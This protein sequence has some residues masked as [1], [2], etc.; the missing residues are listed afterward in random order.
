M[1][2]KHGCPSKKG[3]LEIEESLTCGPAGMSMAN[4]QAAHIEDSFSRR[5]RNSISGKKRKPERDIKHPKLYPVCRKKI[6]YVANEDCEN[7]GF[8]IRRK[9]SI[10]SGFKKRIM[11][12]TIFSWLIDAGMVQENVEIFS[13]DETSKQMK[14]KGRIKREGILCLCCNKVFTVANF[15]VHGGRNCDKPYESVFIAETK[16]S[17][18]SYMIEAWNK[19][20][21]FQSHKFNVIETKGNASDF[22]D[23]ACMICADGG[24]LICC[25]ECNSTYHQVCMGMEDIPE[26]SWYC[27]Y[28]VCKFCGKPAHQNDYL[29]NCPQCEKKYHWEC[30]Q[31]K[32]QRKMDLNTIPVAPFCKRSCKEVCDKLAKSM[33][34][35]RNEIDEG[36]SWT[37]LHQ[38]DDGSGIYIDDKYMRTMCHSKLAVA[39]RL[40]EECFEP[41]Q[42]RHTRIKVIP[43]VVYNCG[44]NFSRINFKGFYTAVLEKDDEIISVASLRIHG[45]KLAEMPFIATSEAYRCKGMC[46]K[47]M[48]AIES[49][50]CYLDVENLII[51]S[52]PERIGNWIERYGFCRLD[53]SMKKE[54]MAHNTLMFHD[55]V[56]LEK[57][58]LSS[59]HLA[60]LPNPHTEA[61]TMRGIESINRHDGLNH[62]SKV[63]A[64]LDLNLEPS[65]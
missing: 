7:L 2:G 33:V 35:K 12:A 30:Y 53:V 24:D 49:A 27:P 65:M 38:M 15:H 41:I 17:L 11:K 37:L 64:H 14:K 43:S 1:K 40:M 36:Y 44:S 22:Y 31:M 46:K 32:E 4:E 52:V 9:R 61:A 47:L 16:V 62:K 29:L 55:S 25:E 28:C 3:V 56:R 60:T 54:I 39:R 57:I 18:L 42:D 6:S 26:E 34:G 13:K 63:C 51:P 50:L 19:P 48:V 21:E 45:T 23:D 59:S 20:E 58:L 5:K 8:A 10:K